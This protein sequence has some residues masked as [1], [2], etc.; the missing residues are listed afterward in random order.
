MLTDIKAAMQN[1]S[2]SK[3]KRVRDAE[4]TEYHAARRDDNV[5]VRIASRMAQLGGW[6]IELPERH[7]IWSEELIKIY[8]LPPHQLPTLAQAYDLITEEWREPC[9]LAV[10]ACARYGTPYDMEIEVITPKGRRIWVRT[11]AQAV[12]DDTGAIRRIQG[13]AQD[14]TGKKL[15]EESLAQTAARLQGMLESIGDAFFTV[16]RDWRLTYVNGAAERMLGKPSAALIGRRLPDEFDVSAEME[17]GFHEAI[18]RK[19]R[20]HYE[21]YLATLGCWYECRLYPYPDGMVAYFTDITERKKAEEALRD[22]EHRFRMVARATSDGI[23][24]WDLRKDSVWMNEGMVGLFDF[25]RQEYEHA[26]EIWASRVHPDE[27]EDVAQRLTAAMESGSDTWIDEYRFRRKDGSYACLHDRTLFMR[28]ADNKVHRVICSMSDIT[29]RKQIERERALNEARLQRQASLLD[30][31]RDAI[32]VTDIDSR[33]IFWNK[34]A[35]HMFG[36]TAAEAMNKN[37]IE[38]LVADDSGID[39]AIRTLHARGEWTGEVHKWRK[40]G[41]SL[42]VEAHWTLVRDE[43]G[44]PESIMAIDTDITERKLAEKKIERLAFYDPLTMLPNRRLLLDRLQHALLTAERTGYSGALLFID[45]DNFK[46][47]ND[48]L[49]HDMGD[50]LLQQVAHRIESCVRKNNTVSRLGGD[51]FVVMLENLSTNAVEAANQAEVVAQQILDAFHESFKLNNHDYRSTP[52][53]GVALFFSGMDKQEKSVDELLKRADMAMYQAK[54]AG[55]NTVR[56]FDPDTQHA[57]TARVA[58][59]NDL[60]QGVRR[61]E[62][63]LQYQPLTD[64]AGRIVGTEAL[65]RWQHPRQGLVAP[66]RFIPLAEETGIIL[67]LGNW[68]LETACRQ[69]VQWAERPETAHLKMSVNVSPRQ[70]RDADFVPQVIAILRRTGADPH[71]LKLELTESMLVENVETTIDKMSALRAIGV[72]FALD[73]FGTGYSSLTYLKR[74]PLDQIKIDQ[75]FVRDVL[76]DANDA[77]IARTIVALGQTFGLE[78]VAEGVETESQRD[79]LANNGCHAYQGFFFSQPREGESF[80]H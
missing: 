4:D 72:S 70:F 2:S 27:R 71:L 14:I 33:I 11:I 77:A 34:G 19:R 24:D 37:K 16:D 48:T 38:L 42:T 67:E 65:V 31:A 15:V 50:K 59:E 80:W 9:R 12:R 66:S 36:W 23:W 57:I 44:N 63:R 55:R 79:F 54:A 47:L 60:R 22:S 7:L 10:E 62:F 76:T 73:D 61:R 46:S 1:S 75:S 53:I 68:V 3:G 6:T 56:F 52:S 30:K 18:E 41:S 35:E 74:L 78:V 5:L 26:G 49:G 17:S 40:D 43:E 51:E 32:I 8:E 21:K 20:V 69:L 28:D 29:E 45:L 39:E 25:D 64:S 13:A 58:L